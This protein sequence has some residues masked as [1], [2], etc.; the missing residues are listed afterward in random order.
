V[1]HAPKEWPECHAGYYGAFVR[2]PDGNKV[3]AVCHR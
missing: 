2:F 1:L 3:E